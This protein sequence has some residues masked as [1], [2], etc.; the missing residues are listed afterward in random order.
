[1]TYSTYN[2]IAQNPVLIYLGY[3][4]IS[5]KDK[6]KELLQVRTYSNVSKGVVSKISTP[7]KNSWSEIRYICKKKLY[8]DFKIYKMVSW[9]AKIWFKKYVRK[10]RLKLAR[11][12]LYLNY[13]LKVKLPCMRMWN[14]SPNSR[15]KYLRNHCF[16][17]GLDPDPDSELGTRFGSRKAQ[18][19]SQ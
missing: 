3:R 12:S 16:G 7:R 19:I 4:Y 8:A 5:Y 17:P 10:K 11:I 18:K 6:D 1:M 9:K 14:R 2:C 15:Y 13:A